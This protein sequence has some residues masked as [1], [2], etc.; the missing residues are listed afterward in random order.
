MCPACISTTAL[1]V[2]GATS[3]AGAAALVMKHLLRV[4]NG[5][6]PLSKNTTD[7]QKEKPQ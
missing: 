4:K 1:M 7:N 2:A 5:L 3:T 6:R